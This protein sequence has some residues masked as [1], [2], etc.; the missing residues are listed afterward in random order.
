M[1]LDKKPFG[2]L[3]DGRKIECYTLFNSRGMEVDILPYGA[4]ISAIRFPD[5]NHEP[6]DVVL[7]FD[8]LDGYLGDHPY[9]G[10]MVGR[11][12]NRIGGARFDIDGHVYRLA[13]NEGRNQLHGGSEGFHRKPW[14]PFPERTPEQVGLKL[15]WESTDGD[16]GFPGTLL[17]E[18][19][20]TLNDRNELGIACRAKTDKPTHVNLTNHSYFNLSGGAGDILDHE[21]FLD[22]DRYTELDKENIPTGRILPV[23]DT[24]FDFR[25]SKA[26]G[27]DLDK[28][29]PGYDINYVCAMETRDLTRIAALH[30]PRSG[31]TMEVLTTLPGVQLYTANYVKDLLGKGRVHQAHSAVCLET[32]Y[33]PDSPNQGGFPST[34][35]R[36]GDLY[37]H[38]TVYRFSV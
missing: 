37:D 4:T 25:I 35:L 17:V 7:G 23:E 19:E 38:Q 15:A 20:Y 36:P 10:C 13:A 34:L 6:G 5:K 3:P 28:V 16:Q 12:C 29:A 24:P 8:S 1:N 32:Q 18:V 9:L 31:R 21:L 22:A 2:T 30:D 27:Q 26:I 14:T 11:Y 33:F